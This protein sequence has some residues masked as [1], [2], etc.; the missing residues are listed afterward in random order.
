MSQEVDLHK[1][2]ELLDAALVSK[3]ENVQKAL[4]K[5]LFIAALALD[6]G[7]ERETG[8]IETILKDL[9]RRV[10]TLERRNAFQPTPND[11]YGPVK[12]PT[13]PSTSPWT[14]WTTTSVYTPTISGGSGGSVSSSSGYAQSMADALTELEEYKIAYQKNLESRI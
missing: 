9:Q 14:T 5:F 8:P 13:F 1:L 12:Y 6:N 11:T 4:R 2:I 3:D 10:E 7:D